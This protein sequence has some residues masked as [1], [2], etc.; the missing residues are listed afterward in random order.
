MVCNDPAVVGHDMKHWTKDNLPPGYKLSNG[1]RRVEWWLD[2]KLSVMTF[3]EQVR[4][5]EL[6]ERVKIGGGGLTNKEVSEYR[7]LELKGLGG[8]LR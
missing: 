2:R 3:Q 1:R 4:F 8:L 5:V 7:G 6:N